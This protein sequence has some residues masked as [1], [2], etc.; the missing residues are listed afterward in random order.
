MTYID[1]FLNKITMYRVVLY[2]LVLL[3]VYSVVLGSV[4][5]LSFSGIHLTLSLITILAATWAT[6]SVCARILKI[7]RNVEST[8]ITAFILFFVLMPAT[9]PSGLVPLVL[10]G[11][12]AAS[13]KYLFVLK[14]RH[15][16]NPA[17]FAAAALTL[18]GIG[19]VGWWVGSPFLLPVVLIVGLLVVRKIRRF[20]MFLAYLLAAGAAATLSALYGQTGVQESLILLVLSWPLIFLGTIMLTEPLTA[21]TTKIGRVVY[22]VCVGVLVAVPLSVG[23]FT[24]T[25]AIALILG[26]LLTVA[27]ARPSRVVLTLVERVQIAKSAYEFVFK[28]DVPLRHRAGQYMEWTLGHVPSDARGNRRYFTIASAPSDSLVRLGVRISEPGSSFKRALMQLP[29]GSTMTA[30]GVA[31]EFVLGPDTTRPLAFIAGGI[32]ITPF[33][34]I[35][36]DLDARQETRDCVLVYAASSEDEFAYRDVLAQAE[37]RGVRVVCLVGSLTEERIRESIPDIA[38]RA[39]YISGPDGLVRSL[40]KTVRGLGA[41]EIHRDYFPGL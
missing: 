30:T 39:V 10:G 12:L 6:D 16:F 5:V 24:V 13:S 7:D 20:D 40:A 9:D 23:V 1:A 15:I 25:P 34:S 32:G 3:A 35:L 41:R 31:G 37:V 14:N 33:I 36:R 22:G 11:V 21:P 28:P 26:N 18:I 4:G 19:G 8:Y 17:A 27:I 29:L 38:S 2:G